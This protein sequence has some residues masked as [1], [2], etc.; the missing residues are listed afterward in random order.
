MT[1]IIL[2]I[3]AGIRCVIPI[4]YAASGM[5]LTVGDFVKDVF[6]TV[7]FAF[8]CIVVARL[9]HRVDDLEWRADVELHRNDRQHHRISNLE[10]KED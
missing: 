5:Y 3:I 2:Y 6:S 9:V 4:I 8:L 10:N 1:S 7:A